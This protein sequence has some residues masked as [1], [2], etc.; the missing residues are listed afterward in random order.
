M[1]T[2]QLSDEVLAARVAQGDRKAFETL[3]DHHA[4]MVLGMALR[5]TGDRIAAEDILQET[6][7]QIWQSAN[8]Y[9]PQR[10]SFTTWLFRIARSLAIDAYR[11]RNVRLQGI[12]DATNEDLILDQMPGLDMNEPEQAQSNLVA[13]KARNALKTLPREQRQV[14]E[15]AYLY[16]MSRQEIAEATGQP[17]D[18]I[19]NSARLG[20]QKLREELES[21]KF[22]F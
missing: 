22:E 16:G 5:I 1:H 13:Q 11:R 15:L 19:H 20:L 14:I 4:S 8:T 17:L 6:F 18:T 2:G 10:G 21:A 12:N 7:W 3:Y 9:Q